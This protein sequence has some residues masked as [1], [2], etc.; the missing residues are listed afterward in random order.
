MKISKKQDS[1]SIKFFRRDCDKMDNAKA[2][3]E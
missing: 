2:R 1:A 3:D